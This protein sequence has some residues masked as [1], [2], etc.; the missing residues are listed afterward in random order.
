[1][2]AIRKAGKINPNSTLIDIGMFGIYGITAVYLIQGEKS[3]LIDAGTRENAAYLVKALKKMGAFHPTRSSSPTR[4][5]ITRKAYLFC[6]RQP[7]K[8]ANR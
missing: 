1:M 8:M 3:C 7:L 2:S 6:N 4:I 5:G